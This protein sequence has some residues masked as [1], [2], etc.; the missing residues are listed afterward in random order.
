MTQD[1]QEQVVA[2]EEVLNTWTKYFDE[3]MYQMECEIKLL[4]GFQE[5][6]QNKWD[7]IARK[8]FAMIFDISK[9]IC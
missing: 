9:N 6:M 8:L 7:G 3:K 4:D 2:L 5:L 1:I